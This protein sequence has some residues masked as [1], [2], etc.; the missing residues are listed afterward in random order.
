MSRFSRSTEEIH[1]PPDFT[2]SFERSQIRMQPCASIRT[3]SPVLNQP[4]AVKLSAP[5][6]PW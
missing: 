3:T 6:P 4:S 1:S 2:R 5:R